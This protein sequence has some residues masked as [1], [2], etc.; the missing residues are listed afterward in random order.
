MRKA[1]PTVEDF[2]NNLENY[3]KNGLLPL[4]PKTE[5]CAK[6]VYQAFQETQN[7]YARHLL[8]ISL[9]EIISTLRLKE[10]Q[11]RFEK[12]ISRIGIKKVFATDLLTAYAN[13][14]EC[15]DIY[16]SEQFTEE[17]QNG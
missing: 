3:V 11:K 14:K 12:I 16:R 8:L 4:M 13:R 10:P 9:A 15:G 17:I 2:Q 5:G 1:M 7:T 6:N